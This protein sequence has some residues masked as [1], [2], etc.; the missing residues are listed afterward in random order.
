MSILVG[1]MALAMTVTG[2]VSVATAP[3]LATVVGGIGGTIGITYVI[4]DL[5][6]VNECNK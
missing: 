3:I 2:I 6:G 5:K 1:I 4:V